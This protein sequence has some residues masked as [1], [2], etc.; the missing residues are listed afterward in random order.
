MCASAGS[1]RAIVSYPGRLQLDD[2]PGR[3]VHLRYGQAEPVPKTAEPFGAGP[4]DRFL[5]L[6]ALDEVW[7]VRGGAGRGWRPWCGRAFV[8]CWWVPLVHRD[9]LGGLAMLWQVAWLVPAADGLGG[10]RLQHH[11]RPAGSPH[12]TSHA[13]SHMIR[14][15]ARIAAAP[16]D[17]KARCGTRQRPTGSG[18]PGASEAQ[19]SGWLAATQWPGLIGLH[20]L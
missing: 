10:V 16:A 18:G 19:I 1:A 3:V 17:A 11:E 15:A 4:G 14:P 6:A 2:S 13:N 5:Q 12:A 9:L 20:R 7:R 8:I